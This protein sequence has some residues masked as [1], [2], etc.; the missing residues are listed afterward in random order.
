MHLI[1]LPGECRS[2]KN[3]K[4]IGY[5]Y[6][7]KK[8]TPIIVPSKAYKDWAKPLKSLLHKSPYR[9]YPWEY[10]VT[11]SFWFYRSTRRKFDIHNMVQGPLDLLVETNIL[12]DDNFEYVIPDL[13]QTRIILEPHNP[14]TIIKILEGV[15]YDFDF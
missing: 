9:Y 5:I 13:R 4:Q 2:L 10:P 1:E 12:E 15:S 11:V 3:S 6:R 8:R 14:R 7:G